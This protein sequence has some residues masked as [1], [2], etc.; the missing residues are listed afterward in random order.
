M[1]GGRVEFGLGRGW[2]RDPQEAAARLREHGCAGVSRSYLQIIDPDD[3]DHVALIA[4]EVM[5][6]VAE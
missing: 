1:S 3:L 6:E 2:F 4:A 5:P